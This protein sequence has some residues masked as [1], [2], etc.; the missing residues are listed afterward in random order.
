MKTMFLPKQ[1]QPERGVYGTELLIGEMMECSVNGFKHIILRTQSILISL[2]SPN[3]EFKLDELHGRKLLP[4]DGVML[5]Q[6]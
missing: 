3:M 1:P 4:G 5:I 6:E 2:T